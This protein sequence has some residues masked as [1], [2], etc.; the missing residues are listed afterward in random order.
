MW[1]EHEISTA[2]FLFLHELKCTL[3]PIKLAV[4]ALCRKDAT[5]LT[6]EGIFQFLFFELK[7]RKSSLAEDLLFSVKSRI[8]QRRQHD[9]VNLIR[10]HQ[11][12][13]LSIYDEHNAH[14]ISLLSSN[15]KDGFVKTTTTL[16][17]RLFWKN[18]S[19]EG[20]G[21]NENEDIEVVN[22]TNKNQEHESLFQRRRKQNEH[23][24]L[25]DCLLQNYGHH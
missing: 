25:Q 14:D 15:T 21:Q 22:N 4:D 13:N 11:N 24:L 5:L 16:F 6:A 20:K 8:Q 17:C 23:F 19:N 9:I 7:K 18:D 10:Y 2:G 12:S 1:I 3:E